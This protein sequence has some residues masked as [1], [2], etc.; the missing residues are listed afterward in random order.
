MLEMV[1][2][3]RLYARLRSDLEPEIL[4]VM[5]GGR[6]I[7]GPD[8]AA[9]EA[10]LAS[11][12]GTRHVVGCGNGTDALRLALMSLGLREGDE[13]VTPA[14]SF[15]AAA[16]A[17]AACGLRP[18]FADIDPDTYGI[19]PQS[20]EEVL[21]PR[22]RAIVPVHLFGRPC[23]MQAV[24]DVAR[25]HNLYVIE[26]NAQSMGADVVVDG[27][28]HK[29]GTVG[30]MAC[31]SFF[32]SK[33]LACMGDGGAVMTADD[34]LAR[35]VRLLASHGA[36]VKYHNEMI[37]FN[38]RL[39]SV[40]AAILRVKLRYLDEFNSR[41]RAA[42]MAYGKSIA[43]GRVSL[44]QVPAGAGAHV[45]HQYTMRVAGGQR[46]ALREHMRQHGISTMIYFPVALSDLPAYARFAPNA[47]R[48]I[49]ARKATAEVLSVPMHSELD[50]ADV[51]AVAAAINS[52]DNQQ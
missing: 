52:F 9:F 16:E 3:G 5:S 36:A 18:V 22:T 20:L 44:P 38:S 45:F 31:T 23:N 29:A 40:Q 8:V 25:R 19:S 50:A 6:Y 30:H 34:D 24:M 15:V 51:A 49:N 46:D 21:T 41:R 48:M 11:Y 1:D 14:F 26:D 10:E 35:R 32:P 43:S 7:N 4:R 42:A 39:D 28:T 47:D 27:R 17:I 2:L 13:V 33:N 12:L 37:G